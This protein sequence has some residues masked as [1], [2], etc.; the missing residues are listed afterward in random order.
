MVM[1]M[2]LKVG[3]LV[4]LCRPRGLS[5]P[6]HK[7]PLEPPTLPA[8]TRFRLLPL[9]QSNFLI[10][11]TFFFEASESLCCFFW[12]LGG[13][14]CCICC[15]C[16]SY[17][18]LGDGPFHFTQPWFLIISS[19]IIS[20]HLI[21]SR[22][23]TPSVLARSPP[24]LTC[25][26]LSPFDLRVLT[27]SCEPSHFISHSSLHLPQPRLVQCCILCTS[28]HTYIQGNYSC[29]FISCITS[30]SVAFHNCPS[31]LPSA[32]SRLHMSGRI[33]PPSI[34]CAAPMQLA[35][36]WTFINNGPLYTTRQRRIPSTVA[37]DIS[38]C[39]SAG[40][41]VPAVYRSTL[42][43]CLPAGQGYFFPPRVLLSTT[44]LESPHSSR[45]L[46]PNLELFHG[47]GKTAKTTEASL[48]P[49]QRLDNS[50][51]TSQ[52]E[53]AGKTANHGVHY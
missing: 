4:R 8:S 36:A 34:A 24:H 52:A 25:H 5:L 17:Y 45:L 38:L 14:C 33:R 46:H 37:L 42:L 50:L 12:F 29:A 19:I 1:V 11:P 44:S 39:L 48:T 28:S 2:G 27:L 41:R 9:P 53:D 26:V 10:H 22:S 16:L 23:K 20:S 6:C 31:S 15:V 18:Y 30:A 13:F 7:E 47:P 51:R 3:R 35:V 49:R 32:I 43:A 21:S 40:A